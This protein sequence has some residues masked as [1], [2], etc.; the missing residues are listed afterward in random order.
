[1]SSGRPIFF[2]IHFDDDDDGVY[3]NEEYRLRNGSMI[4]SY[5]QKFSVFVQVEKRK[6]SNKNNKN[7]G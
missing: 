1:M 4:Q 7:D 6:K 3:K 5:K 2:L